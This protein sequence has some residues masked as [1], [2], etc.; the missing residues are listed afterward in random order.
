MNNIDC[1]TIHE[2]YNG[3]ITPYDI[4]IVHTPHL[5]QLN[6]ELA[7]TLDKLEKLLGPN[8]PI[9]EKYNE[10]MNTQYSEFQKIAFE[11]G[12]SLGVKLT[13]EALNKKNSK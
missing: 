13:F 12:F 6:Q 9:F 3:N 8:N 7:N 10:L 5:L 4:D 2:L 1:K 11:D